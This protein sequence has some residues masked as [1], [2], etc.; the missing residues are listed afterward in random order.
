MVGNVTLHELVARGIGEIC[1]VFEI[2]RVAQLVEIDNVPVG[3]RAQ[4]KLDEVRTDKTCASRDQDAHQA[5]P[6]GAL[7][8]TPS[9]CATSRLVS[10][11]FSWD[12]PASA[13]Q[14]SRTSNASWPRLMYALLT[15][16]ISSSP[17]PEGFSV[18]MI[19]KTEGSYM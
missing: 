10:R 4:C 5:F 12:A 14:P 15:S 3:M 16:V 17:R 18:R 8:L 7:K 19:S 1:E 6:R 9:R 2:A 11:S 13:H